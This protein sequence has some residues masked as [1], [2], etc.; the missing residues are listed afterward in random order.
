MLKNSQ[1]ESLKVSYTI[2]IYL[3]FR[4]SRQQ[5]RFSANSVP[6]IRKVQH[7]V[8]LT[9]D[10]ICFSKNHLRRIIVAGQNE[11]IAQVRLV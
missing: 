11:G 3:L 4:E 8:A 9:F 1:N 2:G 6:A 10:I 7:C 5:P